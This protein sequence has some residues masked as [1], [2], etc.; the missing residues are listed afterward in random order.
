[1][2][3]SILLLIL[4]AIQ[5][6]RKSEIHPTIPFM[7]ITIIVSLLIG[8]IILWQISNFY[9]VLPILILVSMKLLDIL[10][11]KEYMIFTFVFTGL[12]FSIFSVLL[13]VSL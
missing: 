11:W 4:C 7:K 8:F 1:M 5:L 6:F 10:V 12:L 2:V 3:L 13:K 9:I